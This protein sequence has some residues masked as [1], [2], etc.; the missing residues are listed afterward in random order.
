M[1]DVCPK[2]ILFS[3]P[4]RPDFVTALVKRQTD[5]V[6][7][8]FSGVYDWISKS[9]NIDDFFCKFICQHVKRKNIKN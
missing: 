8:N 3:A 9:V 4:P 6:P 2:S 1:K 5:E 7:E